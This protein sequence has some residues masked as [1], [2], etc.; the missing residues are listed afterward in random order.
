MFLN[1][2]SLCLVSILGE[3]LNTLRSLDVNV[4]LWLCLG[5][6][7][8]LVLCFHNLIKKAYMAKKKANFL[9]LIPIVLLIAFLFILFL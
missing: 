5:T 2:S 6:V 9:W 7:L 8:L 1:V 4:K 3:M